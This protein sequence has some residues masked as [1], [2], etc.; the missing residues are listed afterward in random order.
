MD[1]KDYFGLTSSEFLYFL[2]KYS[3]QL[4]RVLWSY[5]FVNHV[6]KEILKISTRL[7]T[8]S[9]KAVKQIQ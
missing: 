8:L 1:S 2:F 3:T 5:F 9:H 6:H 7:L 4:G